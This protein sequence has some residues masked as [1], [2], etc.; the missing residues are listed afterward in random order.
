MSRN[1][2]M[3]IRVY[4]VKDEGTKEMIHDVVKEEWSIDD[5]YEDT[6]YYVMR[7]VGSLCGGETEEEFANKVAMALW[8]KLEKYH[9]ITVE[10]VYLDDLPCETYDMGEETYAEEMSDE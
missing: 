2:E 7:G 6:D 4:N 10:A 1:Y 5:E 3:I 9:R 8:E